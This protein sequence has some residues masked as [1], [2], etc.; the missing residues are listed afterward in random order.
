M[1]ALYTG[2]NAPAN[3]V[4]A[5]YGDDDHIKANLVKQVKPHVWRKDFS[6]LPDMVSL[7]TSNKL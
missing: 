1:Y 5:F 4:V 2:L 3:V 6:K 7:K